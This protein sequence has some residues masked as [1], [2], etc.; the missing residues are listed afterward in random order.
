V[1]GTTA[2]T[3]QGALALGGHSD[4]GSDLAADAG[5]LTLESASVAGAARLGS[6]GA[7][8]LGQLQASG[9]ATVKAGG[10]LSVRELAAAD[11]VLSGGRVTLTS[12]QASKW[13]ARTTWPHNASW[14]AE[15]WR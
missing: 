12:V 14:R 10:D 11:V 1:H 3:T 4:F 8:S 7:A 15:A 5:A 2:L 6:A 13:R 9:T